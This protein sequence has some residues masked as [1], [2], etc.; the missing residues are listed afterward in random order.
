MPAGFSAALITGGAMAWTADSWGYP[1]GQFTGMDKAG[2]GLVELPLMKRDGLIWV[3]PEPDGDLGLAKHLGEL[4]PD[5]A[6]YGF[7]DYH[8]YETRVIRRRLNWKIVIDT[9]LEPYH[10]G[11]LHAD[12]VGLIFFP[13]CACSRASASICGKPCAGAV[14]KRCA[15]SRRRNGPWCPTPPWSMYCFLT[16]SW[17]CR[18]TMWRRGGFIPWTIRL[19]NASCTWIS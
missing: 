1:S 6:S 9:F 11:V 15:S 13:I 10:F 14:L 18:L 7:G 4:G 12:T 5:L 17:S 16:P 19:I 8:H 3:L 2:R